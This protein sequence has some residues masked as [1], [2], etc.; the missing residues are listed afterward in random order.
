MNK[1][2]FVITFIVGL[3]SLVVIG[4][5][6]L[7]KEFTHLENNQNV[8]LEN[9]LVIGTYKTSFVKI[10]ETNELTGSTSSTNATSLNKIYFEIVNNGDVV[11]KFSYV[12]DNKLLIE[13][14]DY[15]NCVFFDLTEIM[16]EFTNDLGIKFWSLSNPLKNYISVR[17]ELFNFP[18]LS[19]EI[20]ISDCG[21]YL[22]NI[23]RFNDDVPQVEHAYVY[24]KNVIGW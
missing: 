15:E 13:D 16:K 19:S 3:L 4:G 7:S 21:I 8:K 14:K 12:T 18:Y 2:S 6:F 22:V 10:I 9:K 24:Q 11:K 23:P 5:Y 17:T 1:K 20:K